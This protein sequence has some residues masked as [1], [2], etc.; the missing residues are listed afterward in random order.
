MRKSFWVLIF[1]LLSAALAQN[2]AWSPILGIGQSWTVSITNVAEFQIKLAAKNQRGFVGQAVFG[3]KTV[4]AEIFYRSKEDTLELLLSP[5]PGTYACTFTSAK[6][7]NGL[8]F[9]GTSYFLASNA[10]AYQNLQR[11]C[12]LSYNDPNLRGA[13]VPAVRGAP[14]P[15]LSAPAPAPPSLGGTPVPALGGTPVPAL[16]GVPISAESLT[17]LIQSP[18]SRDLVSQPSTA[19]AGRP[20]QPVFNLGQTWDVVFDGLGTWAVNLFATEQN[21]PY[22]YAVGA[23]TRVGLGL[24]AT[25]EQTGIDTDLALFAVASQ[26]NYYYCILLP[27]GTR[28][29]NTWQGIGAVQEVGQQDLVAT[30]KGCQITLRPTVMLGADSFILIR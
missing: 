12:V 14:V 24:Y 11:S 15:A 25:R 22:G 7:V 6:S 9:V 13:P 21:I 29:N 2:L 10:V 20:W 18:S 28:A 27:A 4:N 1:M 5:I 17:R 30:G 16:S 8:S 23:D 26:K 3:A 19:V